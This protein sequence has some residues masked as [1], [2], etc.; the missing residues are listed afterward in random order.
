MKSLLR[1]SRDTVAVRISIVS[2]AGLAVAVAVGHAIGWRFALA[3]WVVTAGLYVAWTWL[4]I[5]R[6]DADQTRE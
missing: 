2:V 6:M 1:L 5:G 4:I 3:G